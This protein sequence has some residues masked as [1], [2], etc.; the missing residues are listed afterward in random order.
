MNGWVRIFSRIRLKTD[1]LSII[2]RKQRFS[3]VQISNQQG[4]FLKLQKPQ[5]FVREA[6]KEKKIF[7]QMA[8][9]LRGGGGKDILNSKFIYNVHTIDAP[10][11]LKPERVLTINPH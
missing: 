11:M 9:P 3:A 4:R 1:I 8:G 2:W 6:A 10:S 5:S 7:S